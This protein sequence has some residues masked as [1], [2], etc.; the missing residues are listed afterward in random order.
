MLNM[1]RITLKGVFRD[2]VFQG[3]MALAVLFLFIPSAASLSMRQV[4]ELSVTLSLSLI[5]FILLLLS[6]FLGGT[7]LWRDIERRYTFG[8][9][10]LPLSRSSYILGRFLGLALFLV[11]VS[12]VLGVAACVAVNVASSLY[13]ADRPVVWSF[14]ALAL[15]YATLKYILLVAVALLLSTVSTSFF[16]PVFGTICT[17]LASGISQQVYEYVHSAAAVQ[18][19]SPL[20][21]QVVTAVYYLIPNLAGFDLKINAIYSVAPN[22]RGLALTACYF[23]AYTA[24]LLAGSIFLFNRR[25]MK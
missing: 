1:M 2:R 4:T 12:V 3:I 15:V 24:I 7:S 14:V 8:V 17:F 11:L 23:L 9:L 22:P 5:S 16:L 21:R 19:V 20:F 10:S 18:T 13:P 25:E 6:V